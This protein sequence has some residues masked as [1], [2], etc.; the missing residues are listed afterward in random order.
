MVWPSLTKVQN[1][2]KSPQSLYAWLSLKW[3]SRFS[4]KFQL[5]NIR[6]I[7]SLRPFLDQPWITT[8]IALNIM[9]VGMHSY[10]PNAQINLWSNFNSE[11]LVKSETLLC[12]FAKL[13]PKGG[14]NILE[15]RKNMCAHLSLN[16]VS[17][18]TLTFYF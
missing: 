1:S 16:C 4:F 10:L 3:V 7:L 18:S 13:G 9:K 12:G 11:K 6:K 15:P 5:W 17:K 8:K 14:E 2:S